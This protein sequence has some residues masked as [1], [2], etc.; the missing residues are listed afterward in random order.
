MSPAEI[1]SFQ[2]S[3]L[4]KDLFNKTLKRILNVLKFNYLPDFNRMK[5]LDINREHSRLQPALGFNSLQAG[6]SPSHAAETVRQSNI[7]GVLAQKFSKILPPAHR[8]TVQTH[9]TTQSMTGGGHKKILKQ[10]SEQFA[11]SKSKGSLT[12][13]AHQPKIAKVK[14][15]DPSQ[16]RPFLTNVV[17]TENSKEGVGQEAEERKLV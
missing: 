2:H 5:I 15:N 14:T 3:R 7:F 8:G 11:A 4:K 10:E 16:A 17:S 13:P 1:E 12:V 9:S 6:D